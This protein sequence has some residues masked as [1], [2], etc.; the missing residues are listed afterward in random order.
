[1]SH[2]FGIGVKTNYLAMF[3]NW[4]RDAPAKFRAV[5]RTKPPRKSDRLTILIYLHPDRLSYDRLAN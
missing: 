5:C 1:M 2:I 4:G 3:A